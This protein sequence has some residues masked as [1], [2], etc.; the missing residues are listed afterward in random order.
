MVEAYRP[1]GSTDS[2]HQWRAKRI[3]RG[4]AC[5][6][7]APLRDAGGLRAFN[8]GGCA[9]LAAEF[10]CHFVAGT[11][12]DFF[13]SRLAN[14]VRGCMSIDT[15]RPASTSGRICEAA[16]PVGLTNSAGRKPGCPYL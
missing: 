11:E 7:P 4:R 3:H 5:I 8:T 6:N 15:L 13:P 10:H 12:C 14:P 9:S 2:S 1:E 16:F